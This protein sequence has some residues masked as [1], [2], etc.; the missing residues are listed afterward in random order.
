MNKIAHTL[1]VSAIAALMLA[2]C[3]AAPVDEIAPSAPVTEVATESAPEATP[4]ATVEPESAPEPLAVDE[5]TKTVAGGDELFLKEARERIQQVTSASDEQLIA[6]AMVACDLFAEGNS[7]SDMRLVEGEE[8]DFSGRYGDS[9]AISTWAAK[10]YC[11]EY[12]ELD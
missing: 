4:E 1:T 7:R 5:G 9:M 11:P 2:G 3:S 12:D 6:A 8:A 10:A